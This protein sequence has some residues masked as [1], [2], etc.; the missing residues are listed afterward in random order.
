MGKEDSK[1]RVIAV[2]RMIESGKKFSAN[3]ILNELERKYDIVADR[4]TIYD[5]IR[6]VDSFIPIKSTGGWN[7]GFVKF[8]VLKEVSEEWSD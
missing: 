5:D 7:G 1:K 8:D 6:A 3:D 4:K 2:Y